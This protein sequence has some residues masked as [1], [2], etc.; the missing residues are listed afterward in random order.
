MARYKKL[1]N[2]AKE[3]DFETEEEY[4]EY[5]IDSWHNGQLQQCKTLMKDMC[6]NDRVKAMSYMSE[7]VNKEPFLWYS[8]YIT[9]AGLRNI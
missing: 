6:Y 8:H 2:L 4:F 3:L 1:I 5:M 7:A 9:E